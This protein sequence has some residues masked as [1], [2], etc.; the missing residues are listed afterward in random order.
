M[1]DTLLFAVEDDRDRMVPLASHTAEIAAALDAAV[2]LF[3][4]YDPD[5]F[6]RYL[7]RMDY[8]SSDPD[9][10]AK[11]NE[12]VEACASVFV[13]SG[14]RPEI[15]GAVGDP[16]TEIIDRAETDEVDHIVLGG[17]RRTPVGKALL[18]SVSQSVLRS[19]DVPCT[20]GMD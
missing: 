2:V 3:H 16:A 11:R 19:V 7:E 12:T 20:I 1:I 13:D 18:G 15:A 9:D 17:R 5:E 8:S 10:V 6:D 14:V 4:V